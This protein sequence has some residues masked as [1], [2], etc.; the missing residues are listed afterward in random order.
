MGFNLF[1][2]LDRRLERL[3]AL[4]ARNSWA[5]SAYATFEAAMASATRFGERNEA[6]RGLY[7]GLLEAVGN[8]IRPELDGL[9]NAAMK[10]CETAKLRGV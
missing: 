5:A 6:R 1:V 7:N 10:R 4:C 9:V 8:S 3:D 2:G